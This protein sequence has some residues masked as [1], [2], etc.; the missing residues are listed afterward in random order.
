LQ[1]YTPVSLRERSV[2]TGY[3][4]HPGARC[5]REANPFGGFLRCWVQRT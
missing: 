4:A 5:Q 1:G 2:K 3:F